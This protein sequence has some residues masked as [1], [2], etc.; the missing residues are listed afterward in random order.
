MSDILIFDHRCLLKCEHVVWYVDA[1]SILIALIKPTDC[2]Q[3]DKK[4]L[5]LSNS[6][7]CGALSCVSEMVNK[8][9]CFLDY[10]D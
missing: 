1:H 8:E 5:K 10:N 6:A 7:E 2:P 4:Y 3:L 9:F